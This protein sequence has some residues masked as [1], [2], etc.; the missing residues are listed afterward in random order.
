MA[1]KRSLK[2]EIISIASELFSDT[3]VLQMLVEEKDLSKVE[4]IMNQIIDWMNNT[5]NKVGHPDAKNNT[6]M[7][8][9]YYTDLRQRIQQDVDKMSDELDAIAETLK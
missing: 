6:K 4:K 5:I 8:K 3:I 9:K 2:K 1:S 7:L